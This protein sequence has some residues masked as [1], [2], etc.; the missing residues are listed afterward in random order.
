M[1]DFW[2]TNSGA[3]T[4]RNTSLLKAVHLLH[5]AIAA[6]LRAH[7]SCSFSSFW[8]QGLG[9]SPEGELGTDP[10][11]EA[12]GHYEANML[13]T[14]PCSA[15]TRC[16]VRESLGFIAVDCVNQ[17]EHQQIFTLLSWQLI[18]TEPKRLSW[19]YICLGVHGCIADTRNLLILVVEDD[20]I[21]PRNCCCS[22]LK[23]K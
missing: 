14:L 18:S 7:S 8:E 20:A 12:R 11:Q 6:S 9:L 5:W 4:L 16:A 22:G 13:R 23:R 3:V 2:Q 19:R 21:V 10:L 1:K 17:N 15:V